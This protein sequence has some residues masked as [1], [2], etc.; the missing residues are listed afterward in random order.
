MTPD[1]IEIR[2]KD[3]VEIL[4][5]AK[6]WELSIDVTGGDR[7]LFPGVTGGLGCKIIETAPNIILITEAEHYRGA[8]RHNHHLYSISQSGQIQWKL[9]WKI[10]PN[11][12]TYNGNIVVARHLVNYQYADPLLELCVLNPRDG[13]VLEKHPIYTPEKQ[14]ELFKNA[15]FSYLRA[16]LKTKSVNVKP[17]F[18]ISSK[19]KNADAAFSWNIP[20]KVK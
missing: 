17:T 8:S 9:P 20:F 11:V 6:N 13:K 19:I 16:Q 4:I 5:K 1:D 3:D 18:S 7:D 14:K 12:R 2:R 15:R 10:S